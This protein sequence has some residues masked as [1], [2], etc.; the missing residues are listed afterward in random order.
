MRLLIVRQHFPDLRISDVS[1]ETRRQLD[2]SGFAS[3]LQAGSTVGI[4]VGSRGI[5]NLAAIVRAAVA[6]WIDRGMRPFI[7]PAM[8]SHGAATPEGQAH[9][10]AQFGV[11]ES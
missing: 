3:R 8:G 9:V 1:A 2:Q 7:F 4:G 5:A 10:L 6:Y 11:T